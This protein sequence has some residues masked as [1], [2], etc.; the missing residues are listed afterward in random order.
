MEQFWGNIM[1][2]KENI[3]V[4]DKTEEKRIEQL[5]LSYQTM[6]Y[7]EVCLPKQM[8]EGGFASD[9]VL[10]EKAE[11]YSS[12]VKYRDLLVFVMTFLEEESFIVGTFRRKIQNFR[13]WSDLNRYDAYN[14]LYQIVQKNNSCRFDFLKEQ[15]IL[16]YVLENGFRYFSNL[17]I[18]FPKADIFVGADV[19]GA[20]IFY[21]EIKKLENIKNIIGNQN[22]DG[23]EM[24]FFES[25]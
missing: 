20:L 15:N 24:Y 23:F 17:I 14:N 2:N 1:K 6:K 25:E 8:Q 18:Y 22:N 16:D 21:G 13:S 5:F 4:L 9:S 10:N 19:H 7:L 3:K 11:F 12:A